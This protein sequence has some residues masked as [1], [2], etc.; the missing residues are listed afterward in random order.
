MTKF[1]E[2]GHAKNV[3]NFSEIIDF[4]KSY[5]SD[6]NPS[7]ESIQIPNLETLL[8]NSQ[9]AINNVTENLIEFTNATST[10]QNT[11]NPL[12]KLFTKIT[13]AVAVTDATKNT[14][15]DTKSINKKI[16]GIRIT[17][18]NNTNTTTKETDTTDKRNI[19]TSQQ[20]YDQKIEHTNKMITLLKT[21]PSYNPNEKELQITTLE[22]LLQ[23]MKNANDLVTKTYVNLSNSRIKRNQTLYQENTGLYNIVTEI[24]KY[25]KSVFGANSPQHKQITRMKFSPLNK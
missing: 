1:S 2:I 16:Q 3:A 14:I 23:N 21:I 9:T 15:E 11:F 19:S 5:G 4:C 7:K 20:S 10:R 6:Y 22:T 25:I 24:K 17:S 18:K 13:N 12:K 8:I